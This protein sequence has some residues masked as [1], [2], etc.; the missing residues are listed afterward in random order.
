MFI[1]TSVVY[2]TS[3]Q[4]VCVY[5]SVVYT[6]THTYVCGTYTVDLNLHSKALQ[7]HF[8]ITTTNAK[9][10]HSGLL[11]PTKMEFSFPLYLEHPKQELTLLLE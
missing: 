7:K 6:H 2:T 10:K 9:L 1:E 3:I 5:T 11:K 4:Q 8:P